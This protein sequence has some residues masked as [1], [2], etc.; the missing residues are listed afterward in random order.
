MPVC[1]ALDAFIFQRLYMDRVRKEQE[2]K[3]K[4][5]VKELRKNYPPQLMRRLYFFLIFV[6]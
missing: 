6:F 2:E 3:R 4:I 1:D 5:S